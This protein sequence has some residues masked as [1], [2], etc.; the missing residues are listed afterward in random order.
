MPPPPCARSPSGPGWRWAEFTITFASKE[1]IF[2][3][4]ILERHPYQQI[5]PI[6]LKTP[7]R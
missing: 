5:L 6:L 2:S 3:E 1:A 7:S 4:L